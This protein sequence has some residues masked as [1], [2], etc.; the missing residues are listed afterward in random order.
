[1]AVCI[2]FQA[3]HVLYNVRPLLLEQA[4]LRLFNH[5]QYDGTSFLGPSHTAT[6]PTE[7][8]MRSP[9]LSD[10]AHQVRRKT[11]SAVAVL[12]AE[13][14]E[15]VIASGLF[16]KLVTAAQGEKFRGVRVNHTYVNDCVIFR[17]NGV[18]STFKFSVHI[19]A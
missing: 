5:M 19:D 3:L 13:C 8:Q 14:S 4:F 9:L 18:G 2:P 1:M 17:A 11:S 10:I 12:A 6:S 16:T 15:L 7:V